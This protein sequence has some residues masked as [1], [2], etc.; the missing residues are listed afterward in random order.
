[1]NT[2]EDGYKHLPPA[3]NRH[4]LADTNTAYVQAQPAELMSR[5]STSLP[6]TYQEAL[7]DHLSNPGDVTLKQAYELGRAAADGGLEVFDLIRLHHQAIAEGILPGGERTHPASLAPM[8]DAFLLEVLSPFGVT[9][10]S[11]CGA[12]DRSSGSRDWEADELMARNAELEDEISECKRSEAV[13]QAAKDHYFELYQDARAMEANLRDLSA[14]VLTAQEEE[15]K[16]ISRELHDEIGQALTAINVSI[17]MLKKQ[18]ASDPSFLHN[19][20]EAEQLLE[21]TMET[22]H[23]FARELR[24]AMLDHLG[25]QSA[26]RAHNLAFARRTGIRTEL[27]AHPRLALLDEG[28]AEVLF[29]VAQEA[30]NNV[31]KHAGAT[32]AKIEFTATEDSITMEVADNGRAFDLEEHAA[33][34]CSGRLGLLGMQ[35]R[36]RLVKGVF[37]IESEPGKG[38]RVRARVPL[39]AL[40]KNGARHPA[41]RNG[42][43][44][45]AFIAEPRPNLYEENI[46]I[47]R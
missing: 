47:A 15:R 2:P 28:R 22:V 6:M 37:S 18:A 43:S 13:V 34:Q 39:D 36:V 25:L 21:R 41:G 5:I 9:D 24:P 27:V 8:L 1:M 30:L 4:D 46:C 3:R 45:P 16:R 33:R 40:P 31:Y 23:A 12:R 32:C 26:L 19:V 29:R 42:R 35:E 17:A 11:P 38:T 20:A 14:Q 10:G 44:L 7:R